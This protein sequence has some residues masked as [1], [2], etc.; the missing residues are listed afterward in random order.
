MEAK[1]IINDIKT[2]EGL[3]LNQIVEIINSKK[4]MIT[5][6]SNLSNKL[7]R[8]SIKFS[9]MVIILESLGYN[10]EIT[11]DSTR[12]SEISQSHDEIGKCIDTILKKSLIEIMKNEVTNELGVF[13][14]NS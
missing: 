2:Q 6:V 1:N 10:I 12:L 3:T 8:N 9:E 13:V 4:N 14:N 5:S 7:Q 11:K